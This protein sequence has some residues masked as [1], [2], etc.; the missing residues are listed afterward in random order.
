MLCYKTLLITYSVRET[1]RYFVNAD[2]KK[3]IKT[4]FENKKLGRKR[5]YKGLNV[6]N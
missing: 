6:S 5:M 1:I 2:M 4:R 3:I